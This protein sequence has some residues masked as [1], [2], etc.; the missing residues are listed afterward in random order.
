MH[1]IIARK[2]END[3]SI[4]NNLCIYSYGGQIQEGARK[5]A[6][7]LLEYVNMMDDRRKKEKKLNPYKIY[8]V[9]YEEIKE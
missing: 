4:V 1:Y 3:E 6:Q 2:W 9:I 5:D 8:K 7:E